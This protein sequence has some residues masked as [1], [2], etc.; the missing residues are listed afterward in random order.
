[1]SIGASITAEVEDGKFVNWIAPSIEPLFTMVGR[2]LH[3]WGID[4]IFEELQDCR[5]NL[6]DVGACVGSW[7]IVQAMKHP[8][9]NVVCIEACEENYQCILHNAKGLDNVSTIHAA[10]DSKAGK[11][12][13][14]LPNLADWEVDHKPIELYK[15]YGLVT[16]YGDKSRMPFK[17]NAVALDDI[18]EKVDVLKIDVE[19]MEANVL[20]GAVRILFEQRPIIQIEMLERNQKRAGHTVEELDNSLHYYDYVKMNGKDNADYVYFPR[21]GKEFQRWV[22]SST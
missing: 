18:I 5:L 16:A 20:A 7:G 6:V 21:E 13:M 3:G 19:G 2:Y 12:E 8:L 1:M 17:V 4:I 22:K 15:N 11:V 14:S 9:Y 10:A